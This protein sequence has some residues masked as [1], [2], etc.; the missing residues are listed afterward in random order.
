LGNIDFGIANSGIYLFLN[1]N[2]FLVSLVIF[3][4]QKISS[5]QQLLGLCFLII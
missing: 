1:Y 2:N 5:L 3:H 4:V